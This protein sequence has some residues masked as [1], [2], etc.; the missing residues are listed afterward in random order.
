M[1]Q[2]F[3]A[4]QVMTQVAYDYPMFF[5]CL[6]IDNTG[7]CPELLTSIQALYRPFFVPT[8]SVF[9]AYQIWDG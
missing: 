4:C 1:M 6:W 9:L 2:N 8:R 7:T 5:Y 3:Y